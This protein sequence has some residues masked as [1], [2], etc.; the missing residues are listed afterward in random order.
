MTRYLTAWLN[1]SSGRLVISI[2]MLVVVLTII[3]FFNTQV[4]GQGSLNPLNKTEKTLSDF[5]TRETGVAIIPAPL[6]AKPK[7]EISDQPKRKLKQ[8]QLTLYSSKK[9]VLSHRSAPYGRLLECQLV[10]TVDSSRIETPIIGLVISD[11]WH[12]GRLIIAAGTEIHGKAAVDRSRERIASD[13]KWV[14]VWSD[15][16]GRELPV[17]GI[18]LDRSLDHRDGGWRL[19][20]GS[21]GL[22]GRV[23]KSDRLA[24]LK[25]LAASFIQGLA[26]GF[27]SEE[28]LSTESGTL[29]RF[30][31]TVETALAQ[32]VNQAATLYAQSMLRAIQ[33]DGFFVRV[34]AGKTFYVYLTQPIDAQKARPGATL[35]KS[36]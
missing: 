11:V 12:D 16:S 7:K 32:G 29:S 4:Q 35:S 30:D 17:T 19:V 15:G 27:A 28:F 1:S 2:V 3:W 21:A 31:G 5:E 23:I 6:P 8:P 34:P 9:A 33:R 18:A 13:R 20:D 25:I 24:E 36:P 14:L 26:E 22:R 10:V